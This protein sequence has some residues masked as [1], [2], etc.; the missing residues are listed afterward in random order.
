[1]DHGSKTGSFSFTVIKHVFFLLHNRSFLSFS[2]SYPNDFL[3][4]PSA[5]SVMPMNT[6]AAM[7]GLTGGA[8]APEK[9]RCCSFKEK[10]TDS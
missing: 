10:D 9:S 4:Q 2:Q 3:L 7:A 1:M 6:G 8:T 5:G